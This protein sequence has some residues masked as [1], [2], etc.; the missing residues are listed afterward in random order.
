[1][2]PAEIIFTNKIFRKNKKLFNDNFWT[3][4]AQNKHFGKYFCDLSECVG[5]ERGRE[6]EREKE[7]ESVRE[8][9]RENA[10]G[11]K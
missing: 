11:K 10:C 4:L 5:R 8:G 2:H 7:R 6:R 1:M 9:E 3:E